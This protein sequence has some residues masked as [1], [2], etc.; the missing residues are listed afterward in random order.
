MTRRTGKLWYLIA[1]NAGLLWLCPWPLHAAEEERPNAVGLCEHCHGSGGNSINPDNPVLAGQAAPYLARQLAA[2]RDGLR[3]HA[4]MQQVAENLSHREI[5]QF[6]HYFAAATRTPGDA[7]AGASA[8]LREQG[9]TLAETRGCEGCHPVQ[10]PPDGEVPGLRGQ[11]A[12]YLQAQ[13]TAFRE[14]G[15]VDATGVMAASAAFLKDD[16]IDA[17]AAWFGSAP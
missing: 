3:S 2:Y 6:A 11:H 5:L 16:E 10:I 8:A 15:R 4:L 7:E 14:G 12:A 9:R 13:L 17:L 1:L